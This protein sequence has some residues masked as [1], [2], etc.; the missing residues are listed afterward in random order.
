MRD[1]HGHYQRVLDLYRQ[2]TGDAGDDLDAVVLW[3]EAHGLLPTG[4]PGATMADVEPELRRIAGR[5]EAE[6]N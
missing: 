4:W 2:A 5:L 3:A 1:Y 6:D